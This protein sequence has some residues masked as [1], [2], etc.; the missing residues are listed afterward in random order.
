M[1]TS[2]TASKLKENIV[3]WNLENDIIPRFKIGLKDKPTVHWVML[4]TPK[5]RNHRL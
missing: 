2:V 4:V 3:Q 1:D 5:V